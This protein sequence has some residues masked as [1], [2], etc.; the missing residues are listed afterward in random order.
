MQFANLDLTSAT[1]PGGGMS[2]SASICR[3]GRNNMDDNFSDN[4]NDSEIDF[5]DKDH[6]NDQERYG[7]MNAHTLNEM[8]MS[9]AGQQS[10]SLDQFDD[11]ASMSHKL[12]N[13]KD[14]GHSMKRSPLSHSALKIPHTPDRSEIH[15]PLSSGGIA[16]L[17]SSCK[18]VVMQAGTG[19][20]YSVSRKSSP[21]TSFR[22]NN[23]GEIKG[24]A[25]GSY[26]SGTGYDEQT[27]LVL[28]RA[29][30]IISAALLQRCVVGEG[31]FLDLS[32]C[33]TYEADSDITLLRKRR[34]YTE[35]VQDEIPSSSLK[36]KSLTGNGIRSLDLNASASDDNDNHYESLNKSSKRKSKK[37]SVDKNQIN[38]LFSIREFLEVI[39][40]D[41]LENVTPSLTEISNFSLGASMR[42]LKLISPSMF[43]SC[44]PSH[45]GEAEK[46]GMGGFGSVFKVCCDSSCN[47]HCGSPREKSTPYQSYNSRSNSG[48]RSSLMNAFNA[49][50]KQSPTFNVKNDNGST[51]FRTVYAIKRIPRERSV[52][53]TPII[54]DVFNE[55]TSLE[56]LAGN[57][58]VS[59]AIILF[60]L[61]LSCSIVYYLLLSCFILFYLILSYTI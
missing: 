35:F 18:S 6:E 53:D 49:G 39:P 45:M 42:V 47:E 15:T 25:K 11:D 23:I 26:L 2:L 56:L 43:V 7:I 48:K 41:E 59:T 22:L 20:R 30:G 44:L 14:F 58:G 40:E 17:Q 10:G 21:M 61:L 37:N 31:T 5:T 13:W 3:E 57:K 1:V 4:D 55:V 51:A 27:L 54:Y 16:S 38:M 29:Y 32:T 60:R 8:S 12:L 50:N 33:S 28:I 46:I 9:M 52:Y 24:S 34:R 19:G 36:S